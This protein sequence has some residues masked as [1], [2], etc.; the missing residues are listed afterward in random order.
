MRGGLVHAR[1]IGSRASGHVGRVNDPPLRLFLDRS[2]QGR[3]FVEAVRQMVPDT[4]TTNGR[5]G[6]REAEK[7]PD[8]QWISGATADGRIL[9][10]AEQ[11][12]SSGFGR[13]TVDHAKLSGLQRTRGLRTR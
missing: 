11:R 9:V 7:I 13:I 8:I 12:M 1:Q 2:T 4:E 6:M 5:Y 10:G 3:R